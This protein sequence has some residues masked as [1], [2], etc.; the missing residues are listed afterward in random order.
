MGPSQQGTDP[1][2]RDCGLPLLLWIQQRERNNLRDAHLG[3]SERF[4]RSGNTITNM[5]GLFAVTAFL[6][7]RIGNIYDCRWGPRVTFQQ[8]PKFTCF[9]A[10]TI[11]PIR[12]GRERGPGTARLIRTSKTNEKKCAVFGTCG[13]GVDKFLCWVRGGCLV[14]SRLV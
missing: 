2:Y 1:R 12:R 10:P 4:Y 11:C 7:R 8:V 13:P 5:Q 9:L 14:P 6:L 3:L